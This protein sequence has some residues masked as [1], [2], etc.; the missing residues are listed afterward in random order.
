[1]G[2]TIPFRMGGEEVVD[3]DGGGMDEDGMEGA[4]VA[5]VV[6]ITTTTIP[7]TIHNK[8]NTPTTS[9]KHPVAST[10][11]CHPHPCISSSNPCF[12]NHRTSRWR[13]CCHHPRSNPIRNGTSTDKLATRPSNCRVA[14]AWLKPIVPFTH[15]LRNS[16]WDNRM[17]IINN[18]S[19]RIK[20]RATPL[21]EEPRPEEVVVVTHKEMVTDFPFKMLSSLRPR[22]RQHPPIRRHASIRVL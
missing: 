2:R 3:A 11:A 5:V 1:M 22:H 15:N 6:G 9:G 13:H 4:G 8:T 20:I 17:V 12:S 18:L 16:R 21:R 14:V 7:T 10:A 19:S